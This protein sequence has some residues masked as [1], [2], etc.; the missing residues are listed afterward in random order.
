MTDPAAV[1]ERLAALP[2][3]LA[4]AARAAPPEPPAPGEWTPAGV[5]RHLIAVE[6][7]K[8]TGGAV[9]Q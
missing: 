6:E 2:E 4:I 5:V 3:R 1:R 9:A 7:L 8:R